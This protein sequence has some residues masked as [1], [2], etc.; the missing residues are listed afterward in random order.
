MAIISKSGSDKH[1]SF[2]QLLH[3]AAVAR[4]FLLVE[5]VYF[6][7]V[8]LTLTNQTSYFFDNPTFYARPTFFT[9]G[10]FALISSVFSYSRVVISFTIAFVAAACFGRAFTLI[11]DPQS[12]LS[13][14]VL[15]TG[16]CIPFLLTVVSIVQIN[17]AR[18]VRKAVRAWENG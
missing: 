13:S 4:L 10:V 15:S 12:S 1:S 5:G 11:M 2:D 6:V 3:R 17:A 7:A 18:A 16:W 9:A 14:I 8:G